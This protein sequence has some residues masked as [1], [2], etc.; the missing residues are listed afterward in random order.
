M[1]VIHDVLGMSHD[2]RR[3]ADWLAGAWYLA[4]APDLYHGGPRGHP[5]RNH[6]VG[7]GT[8]LRIVTDGTDSDDVTA[9]MR[10]LPGRELPPTAALRGCPHVGEEPCS[11]GPATPARRPRVARQPGG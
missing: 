6:R 8:H 11:S 3:Q 4:A 1:V 7:I 9:M 5:A 10:S 2:L